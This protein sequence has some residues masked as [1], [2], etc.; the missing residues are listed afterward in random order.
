MCCVQSGVILC[1]SVTGGIR[2]G[3]AIVHRIANLY[4]DG[5]PVAGIGCIIPIPRMPGITIE[6]YCLYHF[7]IIHS[8]VV[9]RHIV[10]AAHIRHFIPSRCRICSVVN[11][12]VIRLHC[13]RAFNAVF[14]GWYPHIYYLVSHYSSASSSAASA[15]ICSSSDPSTSIVSGSTSSPI[16]SSCSICEI[17]FLLIHNHSFILV[18]KKDN[19][20]WMPL[21]LSSF[22]F[23]VTAVPILPSF[24]VGMFL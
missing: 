10:I 9:G 20:Y 3:I 19:H 2:P 4:T 12:Q 14:A 23:L 7:F 21:C 17:S 11:N 1:G 18:I 8:N 6:W 16:P 15:V 24:D 13:I 5:F 22:S